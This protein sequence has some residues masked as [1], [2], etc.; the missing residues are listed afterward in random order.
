MPAPPDPE[1]TH[2]DVTRILSLLG[3]A[4]VHCWIAGGWGIDALLGSQSR[5]HR[6][7]DLLVAFPD[8]LRA[9][10]V[11]LFDGFVVETD[12]MPTRFEMIHPAGGIVDIHPIRLDAEGGARLE[13]P[14]G[15]WWQYDAESLSGRGSIDG[16]AHPC[17]SPEAQVR[18]HT[19]YDP[20]DDDRRDIIALC[21][22]YGLELPEAYR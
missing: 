4:S 6:D 10:R 7:L 15:T 1:T 11:L 22:H 3:S 8:V 2:E 16:Q 18:A 17:L 5:P 9:H 14:D 20:G 19:G 13:L 21:E 12:Q